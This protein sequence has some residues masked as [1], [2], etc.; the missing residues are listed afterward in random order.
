MTNRDII[1]AIAANRRADLEAEE[2]MK[3]EVREAFYFKADGS[4]WK[5]V[6]AFLIQDHYAYDVEWRGQ[7]LEGY[8]GPVKYTDMFSI[9]PGGWVII[10]ERVRGVSPII[11]RV[12]DEAHTYL[13]SN[14]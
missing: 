9:L 1:D 4:N 6:R 12:D 14:K 3:D 11:L 8:T 13:E 2:R 5:E 7:T 10:I